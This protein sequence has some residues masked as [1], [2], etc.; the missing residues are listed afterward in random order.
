MGFL[1]RIVLK[2]LSEKNVLLV[3]R[4][5]YCRAVVGAL[6]FVACRLCRAEYAESVF[7][8]FDLI[9]HVMSISVVECMREYVLDIMGEFG[10]TF[11]FSK[12]FVYCSA[13]DQIALFLLSS[14]HF[15][16][17]AATKSDCLYKLRVWCP[18]NPS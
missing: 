2:E 5:V 4:W 17:H 16:I 7:K 10:L 1:H 12:D 3:L 8:N 11:S 13:Y 14:K 15:L 6:L 18:N 9:S